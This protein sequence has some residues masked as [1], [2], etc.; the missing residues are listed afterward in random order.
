MVVETSYPWRAG[1]WESMVTDSAA[2]T[3]AASPQGQAQFLRDLVAAV[4]AI[5][6]GHGAGVLWWYP[7]AI[8]VPGLFVWGGGSLAL[9][10]ASGNVLPAASELGA[11][12]S[13]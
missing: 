6:G 4:A 11:L 3:W 5:P 8:Q 7:E 10:D 13:H 1:G 2:M 9:F 12:L